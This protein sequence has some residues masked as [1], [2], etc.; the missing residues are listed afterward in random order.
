MHDDT[1]G[2]SIAANISL[3]RSVK[4]KRKSARLKSGRF[5]VRSG[6]RA[7]RAT[8]GQPP[9]PTGLRPQA[10]RGGSSVG[11]SAMLQHRARRCESGTRPIPTADNGEVNPK[12]QAAV[13]LNAD[14]GPLDV[15]YHQRGSTEIGRRAPGSAGPTSRSEK[16]EPFTRDPMVSSPN[17]CL[18]VSS[19]DMPD[20]APRHSIRPCGVGGL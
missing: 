16:D 18:T 11:H 13:V 4:L 19:Q 7:R 10:P 3:H 14:L 8:G 20:G 5:S 6:G 1:R 12:M 15:D 9:T 17:T 2:G